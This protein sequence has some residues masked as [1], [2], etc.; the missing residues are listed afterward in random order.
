MVKFTYNSYRTARRYKQQALH[1][2]P[3]PSVKACT[4]DANKLRFFFS[5]AT[6]ICFTFLLF[7]ALHHF[8]GEKEMF[9]FAVV[10]IETSKARHSSGSFWVVAMVSA[11]WNVGSASNIPAGG[12][13]WCMLIFL[14]ANVM[15]IDSFLAEVGKAWGF[16]MRSMSVYS[17]L[18]RWVF[19][20]F[21]EMEIECETYVRALSNFVKMV[22]IQ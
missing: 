19:F 15:M 16:G 8:K 12:L 11:C 4:Y 18:S 14:S 20:F 3:I 7:L 5:V 1:T 22:E 17:V 6:E 9:T 13:I 2:L 10:E 21:V